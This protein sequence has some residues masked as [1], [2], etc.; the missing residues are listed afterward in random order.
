MKSVLH[1]Y[2]KHHSFVKTHN[3]MAG[4]RADLISLRWGTIRQNC[5]D[6]YSIKLPFHWAL[7]PPR[8]ESSNKIPNDASNGV[9]TTAVIP[10]TLT[11]HSYHD[12]ECQ[13]LLPK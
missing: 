13:W 4:C 12:P 11:Q 6:Y 3:S 5:F 10:S 1:Q 9:V 8:E 7:C 2:L